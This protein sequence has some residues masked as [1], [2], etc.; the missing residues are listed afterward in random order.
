[1]LRTTIT[2]TLLCLFLIPSSAQDDAVKKEQDKLQGQWKLLSGEDSGLPIAKDSLGDFKLV[3]TGTSYVFHAGDEVEK[4]NFKVNPATT[5][6][7]LDIEIA[8][9]SYK[10]DKQLGIYEFKDSKLKFCL[11]Q[12]GGM[13]RPAK[14]ST[15][16]EDK[17]ILFEFER[18]KK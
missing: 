10:G 16:T 12:P 5:P 9:G 13:T 6:A 17:Y 4:G 1:M 15:T 7:Q 11:A 18:V 2:L 8:E 3:I 14:F